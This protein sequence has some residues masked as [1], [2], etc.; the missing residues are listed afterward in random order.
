MVSELS[1]DQGRRH[2]FEGGGDN[3]AS[4]AKFLNP[5]DPPP[6]ER[7]CERGG[8]CPPKSYGGAALARDRKW[9]ATLITTSGFNC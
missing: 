9:S 3:L 7:P 8:T 6:C 5:H 4:E 2:G 1:C